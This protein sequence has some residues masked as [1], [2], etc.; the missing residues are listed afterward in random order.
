MGEC[1]LTVKGAAE[2]MLEKAGLNSEVARG[3]DRIGY[4]RAPAS[5]GHHLARPGGLVE[6]SINVYDRLM[7][8][9]YA[10]YQDKDI[11]YSSETLAIVALLHDLCKVNFYA[12]G[13]K[14]QKTYDPDKVAAAPRGSVKHDPSGDFIWETV[15]SYTID[16]K[17]VYGHGEKSVYIIRSFMQLSTE[18]A[19]AIRFHMGAWNHDEERNAGNAFSKYPLA[20]FL[21]VADEAASFLDESE[22]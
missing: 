14:N 20:F 13:Y 10:E 21:H 15:P 18:E 9:I 6:H 17:F 3:L 22:E 5:K 4:F 2:V 11:P 7:H 1:H 16:E 19:V 8:F 12:P